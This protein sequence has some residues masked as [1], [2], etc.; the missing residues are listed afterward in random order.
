[1]PRPIHHEII[2]PVLELL[3]NN[4]V[5]KLKE[6]EQPLSKLFNLT[7]DEMS[8]MYASSN[9]PVFYDRI[10]WTISYLNMAGLVQK[11]NQINN[12]IN[13][14]LQNRLQRETKQEDIKELTPNEKIYSSF[15][16]LKFSKVAHGTVSFK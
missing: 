2:K 10:S 14:Q 15:T 3:K 7:Q 11:T 1:M 12:F 9:G 5:I 8:E 4:D 16:L 6:F 13:K